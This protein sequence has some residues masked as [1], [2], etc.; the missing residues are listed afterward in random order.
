MKLT[1]MLTYTKFG[2]FFPFQ[3]CVCA[4]SAILAVFSFGTASEF[5]QRKFEVC[6]N[7]LMF[8]GLVLA[9]FS[10]EEFPR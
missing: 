2:S 10:L 3:N 8:Y 7:G 9:F 1:F 6:N 4:K 5:R